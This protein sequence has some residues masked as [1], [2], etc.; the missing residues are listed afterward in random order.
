MIY[1]TWK[2]KQHQSISILLLEFWVIFQFAKFALVW[3]DKRV[4]TKKK[5][6]EGWA[7]LERTVPHGLFVLFIPDALNVPLLMQQPESSYSLKFLLKPCVSTVHK[8]REGKQSQGRRKRGQSTIPRWDK[9]LILLSAPF[10]SEQVSP[11][12][13]SKPPLASINNEGDQ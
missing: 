2:Q 13:L 7:G 4:D 1:S 6:E 9:T 11:W 12:L 10:F 5:K 8:L 3:E